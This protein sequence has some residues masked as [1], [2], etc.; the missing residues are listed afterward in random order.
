VLAVTPNP[1]PDEA[2]AVVAGNFT[3]TRFAL[4]GPVLI[5][6]RRLGDHRGFFLETY[7]ARDFATLGVPDVFVQDNHAFSAAQGTLRG[8]HFQLPPR[9]QAK[10]VRVLHGAILDVAVDVRRSSPHFGRH[11]AV[12]L[13]AENACQL[14][15]PAGFAHAYCT[16][17][18]DVAVAYKVTD[19]YAPECERAIR[20]DDPELGLPWPFPPELVR[21]SERDRV[22][23]C[24]REAAELFD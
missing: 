5:A 12:E 13:S 14:Y 18:P 7:N 9:A 19:L 6:A 23:P 3:A 8:L 21:L 4:P 10:L 17:T 22:A 2:T 1:G 15:V 20:W 24:L 16:L 11:V